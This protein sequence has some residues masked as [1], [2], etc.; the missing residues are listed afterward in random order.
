ML[1]LLYALASAVAT[2]GNHLFTSFTLI[3][4]LLLSLQKGV[5]DS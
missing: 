2:T 3:Y 4:R 5:L 1:L